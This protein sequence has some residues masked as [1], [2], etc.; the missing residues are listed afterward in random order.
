M[1]VEAPEGVPATSIGALARPDLSTVVMTMRPVAA[2]P[3]GIATDILRALGKR[4]DVN[5]RARHGIED[6]SLVP[7]WL[8][9]HRVE[10]LIVAAPMQPN[11]ASL[12]TMVDLCAVSPTS[13]TF[14]CDPGAGAKV[15]ESLKGH[16]PLTGPWPDLPMLPAEAHDSA[17]PLAVWKPG[18]PVRLPQCEFLNF[19]ATAE[20]TL[21]SQVF[22]EVSNRYI[23]ALNRTHHW[24]AQIIAETAGELPEATVHDGMRQLLTEAQTLDQVT[25]IV[26]AAQAAFFRH[27]WLLKVDQRELRTGLLRFPAPAVAEDTWIRLRAYRDPA[28]AATTALYLSGLTITAIENLTVKDIARWHASPDTPVA[29]HPIP[30]GAAPFVRA[31][32]LTRATDG[33]TDDAPFLIKST[34][35]RVILD[36]RE[37]SG[38]LDIFIGDSSLN[39]DSAHGDRRISSRAFKLENIA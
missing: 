16:L 11:L 25:T 6:T 29:G 5:G 10:R 21:P 23:D 36:V 32:L 17:A 19:Y 31:Q 1:V 28:R 22:A 30:D 20:R 9:A 35:R 7:V 27:G 26:H 18:E 13:V 34:E 2:G 4:T 39:K 12:S 15:A 37:A 3:A 38:D 14:A 33:Y 8:T 24:V